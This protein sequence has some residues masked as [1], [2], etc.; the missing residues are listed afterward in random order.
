MVIVAIQ[1]TTLLRCTCT[2]DLLKNQTLVKSYNTGYLLPRKPFFWTIIRQQQY[3][4]RK[5]S[6]KKE[7]MKKLLANF[8][9]MRSIKDTANSGCKCIS[10]IINS[11][12]L[13]Q[14]FVTYCKERLRIKLR[15]YAQYGYFFKFLL[16][17]LAG[18][19]TRKEKFLTQSEH[20]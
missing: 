16:I 19:N 5:R 8:T 13:T 20:S 18:Y 6:Y 12:H 2:E 7:E 10:V 15:Y 3:L 4:L 9:V 1:C 17:F 11:F 14:Q